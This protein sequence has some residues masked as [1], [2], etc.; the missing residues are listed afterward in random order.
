[1][2]VEGGKPG[3]NPAAVKLV[4]TE[5][6]FEIDRM[7]M[8]ES[9]EKREEVKK[10]ESQ[11]YLDALFFDGISNTKYNA[12]KTD[13]ANQALQVKYAVPRTY[14][15]ALK[16]AG[17]RKRKSTSAHNNKI[18]ARETMVQSGSL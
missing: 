3:N 15:K 17:G 1:M 2:T 16:L 13:I 11:R 9:K 14:D 4:N 18:N 8:E 5:K 6:G 7:A 12:L 10:R